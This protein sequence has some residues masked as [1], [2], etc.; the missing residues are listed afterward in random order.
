MGAVVVPIVPCEGEELAAGDLPGGK[1]GSKPQTADKEW[2]GTRYQFR[3]YLRSG[4]GYV[5]L[6]WK[7]P[8]EVKFRQLCMISEKIFSP[9]ERARGLP[10]TVMNAL[11]LRIVLW[12]RVPEKA[13]VYKERDILAQDLRA[14]DL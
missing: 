1:A 10:F 12:E 9:D 14:H 3:T 4:E 5:T 2:D 8:T 7:C 13:A 6:A 11:M